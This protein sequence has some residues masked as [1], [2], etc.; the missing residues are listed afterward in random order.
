MHVAT[1][2]AWQMGAYA[3]KSDWINAGQLV[4]AVEAWS[5]ETSRPLTEFLVE[6]RS[7]RREELPLLEVLWLKS[8]AGTQPTAPAALDE[9][10]ASADS[11]PVDGSG[12]RFAE[13]PAAADGDSQPADHRR[14][15]V[16]RELAAGGLGQVCVARDPRLNRVVALK[17]IRSALRRHPAGRARFQREAEIT[18]A[19]EHPAI[20]PLY[21]AGLDPDGAPWYAMRLL[22]GETLRDKA[23]AFHRNGGDESGHSG[24]EFRRLL[25]ALVSACQGVAFA[26]SRGIIHR[27]IKPANIMVGE[28]G[29]AVVIDW[30]L[31]KRTEAEGAES[32]AGVADELA[33]GAADAPGPGL[34]VA[35]TALGTPGF[36]SPEQARG[37]LAAIHQASDVF[38]LGAALYFL[39]TGKPLYEGEDSG[40]TLSRARHCEFIRPRQVRPAIPAALE[41]ICLKALR[42]E[43]R[44]RYSGVDALRGDLERWLADEP[45]S[46]HPEPWLQRGFRFARRNRSLVAL[47]GAALLVIAATASTFSIL[48]GRQA[49]IA[50][51]ARGKAVQ[52]AEDKSEL[53][54][55]EQ[56][57]RT[58]AEQQ[59]HLAIRTLRS[60]VFD[61]QRQLRPIETAQ[62]VRQSILETALAGLRD[63]SVSVREQPEVDYSAMVA[64]SD[65]GKVLLLFG[66]ADGTEATQ[67]ALEHFE[68]AREIAE[69]LA[70]AAG[71]ADLEASRCLSIAW[72]QLGDAQIELGALDRAAAAFDA[73]LQT[74]LRAAEQHP[75][76][77]GLFRDLGFGWEKVGDV[78]QNQGDQAGAMEAF[79]K[80]RHAFESQLQLDPASPV[81]QRDCCV[82]LQKQGDL[83]SA[84]GD[85]DGA[86]SAWRDALRLIDSPVSNEEPVFQP[87][88]RSVLLNKIGTALQQLERPDEALA[89]LG[90]SLALARQI[91]AAAPDSRQA[92]RD[93][94]IALRLLAGLQMEDGAIGA[95]RERLLECLALREEL[96][97]DDP[98]SHTGQTDL[99]FVLEQLGR[100]EAQAGNPAE[101]SAHYRRAL[102]T[103]DSLDPASIEAFADLKELRAAVAA[104]LEGDD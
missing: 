41:A 31:A 71:P 57:A 67:L 64:N 19:L 33:D 15:V 101:S 8:M 93:L 12:L 88:D 3:L 4:A 97:A 65:L 60:L 62:P 18:G 49:G 75:D 102:Q 70:A 42:A 35:G 27:D 36:L 53:L 30:G 44:E 100:L 11:P 66:S 13:P 104:A 2:P 89:C 7:L 29:E 96:A 40:S 86:V 103:L 47:G 46:V 72:E 82:A 98:S 85:F 90:D 32:D 76:E 20:V 77:P 24:V 28:R 14:F 80:S 92:K 37:D 50:D 73:A 5:A 25:G 26:H 10:A 68:R 34:T 79:G 48:L 69:S 1:D 56:A 95:A 6:Q 54:V 74:T 94:S 87:R 81:A 22:T 99:A 52:L 45:V 17:E 23:L 39:L 83:L 59:R 78:L 21:E 16:E 61:V 55:L 91:Q 43:P 9:T 38:G 58:E 51:L 63:I 84:A